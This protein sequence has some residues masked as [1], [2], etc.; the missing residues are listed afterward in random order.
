L[1]HFSPDSLKLL[2]AVGQP[3]AIRVISGTPRQCDTLAAD[4]LEAKLKERAVVQFE[5]LLG[6]VDLIVRVDPD[7]VGVERGVVDLGEKQSVRN[8]RL[9]QLLIGIHND[10]DG[11]QQGSLGQPRNRASP[12]ISLEHRISKRGLMKALLDLA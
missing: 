4:V 8:D 6:E 1:I 2:E 9:P 5:Q 7:Q 3:V 11:I 10:V 12:V